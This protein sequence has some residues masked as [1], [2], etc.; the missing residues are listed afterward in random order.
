MT[1]KNEIEKIMVIIPKRSRDCKKSFGENKEVDN[2]I[3]DLNRRL[4]Y[5]K[6]YGLEIL[7]DKRSYNKRDKDFHKTIIQKE[8]IEISFD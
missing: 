4:Y 6:K 1:K 5:L 7:P 3:S 2:K 8:K